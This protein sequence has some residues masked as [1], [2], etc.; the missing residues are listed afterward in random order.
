MLKTSLFV[1]K[2][3]VKNPLK[4]NRCL[5][6]VKSRCVHAIKWTR[7]VE[8][9]KWDSAFRQLEIR[10]HLVVLRTG[11]RKEA[12]KVYT[13]DRWNEEW[14][15]FS[16]GVPPRGQTAAWLTCLHRLHIKNLMQLVDTN[17]C[18]MRDQRLLER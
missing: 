6:R 14:T 15:N 1:W 8:V 5:Y 13:R 10:S 2:I 18:M 9:S 3:I 12:R 17:E 16:F 11:I 7:H 4:S